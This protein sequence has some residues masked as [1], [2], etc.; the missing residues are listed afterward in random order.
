M[1]LIKLNQ[2]RATFITERKCVFLSTRGKAR[3]PY[4]LLVSFYIAR[5]KNIIKLDFKSGSSPIMERSSY[6][7]CRLPHR[8]CSDAGAPPPLLPG[9]SSTAGSPP[10]Q[11]SSGA[12]CPTPLLSRDALARGVK[13]GVC[14]EDGEYIT[15]HFPRSPLRGWNSMCMRHILK[16]VLE[17]RD[18]NGSG[19]GR[20]E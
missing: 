8:R 5:P 6:H 10:P 7:R 1:S 9:G 15:F 18:D 3:C 11:W 17:I 12:G 2:R 13:R 14:V 4:S 19:S 20:V 16:V